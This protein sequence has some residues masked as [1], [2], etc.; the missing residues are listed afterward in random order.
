MSALIRDQHRGSGFMSGL[1]LWRRPVVLRPRLL[2]Q[3][4]C[5]F[6]REETLSQFSGF[7]PPIGMMLYHQLMG[8]ADGND[9]ALVQASLNGDR[10]AFAQ[11]VTRYQALIASVAYSATGN[12]AQS[13]DIAQETF[14]TAWQHL[15]SLREAGKLRSWLCGIARRLTA[16]ARRRQQR[17]PAQ[18]AAPLD[19]AIDTPAPDAIPA[20]RAMTRE[21]ESILWRSLEQ[22]PETYREPLILF[23]R[24]NDSVEQVAQ[25][26]ELSPEAV[27]QRLSRGRKLLEERVA[28]FVQGA[29]RQSAPGPSF[30]LGVL[31]ALPAQMAAVSSASAAVTAAKSGAAAKTAALLGMLTSYAG[32]LAGSLAAYLGYKT[33]LAAAR[34][35][36]ERRRIK[37]FYG[38]VAISVL[39]SVGLVFVA[40]WGRTLALTHPTLY[41]GLVAVVALSWIPAAGLLAWWIWGRIGGIVAR[42]QAGPD[43]NG[44]QAPYYEYRSRAAFLGL[45]LVH[46]RLGNIWAARPAPVRAWIAV[47]DVAM[48]GLFALG[49]VAVAP[50]AMGGFALGA[51]LFGGFGVGILAY[52]GFA[53]GVWTLGGVVA[54]FE[55]VGGCALGWKAAAGGVA[56][57]HDLAQGGVTVA[58]HANDALARAYVGNHAFFRSA[59]LLMTHWLWP[60]MILVTLPSILMWRVARGRRQL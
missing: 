31:S 8:I 58:L 47:G 6:K 56:V 27:R 55:A 33:D 52:A 51:V 60:T 40:A 38:L 14:V 35:E 39:F 24:E 29:L 1:S 54:G 5:P 11:I 43:T 13:E 22:I 32:F 15:P 10:E 45:P 41:A 19:E 34:T 18:D 30:T 25:A 17:E 44:A 46:V 26:L 7:E 20:E 12:L 3:P 36:Q 50:I 28:A 23:Y 9:P 42:G 2:E 57:A 16:N 49:G 4:G 37:R 48:G 53:V 59:H 21:E